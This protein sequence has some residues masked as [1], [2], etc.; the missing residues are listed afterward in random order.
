LPWY[1]EDDGKTLIFQLCSCNTQAVFG[2]LEQILVS[3]GIFL[4]LQEKYAWLLMQAVF[5]GN[6]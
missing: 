5:S 6:P 3:L 1:A 2:F 4:F